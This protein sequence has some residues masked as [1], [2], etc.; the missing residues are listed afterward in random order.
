[1]APGLFLVG[2][3]FVGLIVPLLPTTDI[4][5]LALPCFARSSVRRERWLLG[6][7]R[8]GSPLCARRAEQA[9]SRRANI[10]ACVEMTDDYAIFCLAARPGQI[11]AMPVAAAMIGSAAWIVTRPS[12]SMEA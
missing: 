4:L 11:A 10:A 5:I 7:P 8:V 6:R 3:G 12:P 1:M 9:I 2:I